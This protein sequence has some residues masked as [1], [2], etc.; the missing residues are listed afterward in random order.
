M[1]AKVSWLLSTSMLGLAF[2]GLVA[3][4]NDTLTGTELCIDDVPSTGGIGGMEA[5]AGKVI[6][7][8]LRL[9]GGV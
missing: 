7:S 5:A 8:Q 6:Q 3:D 2:S 1:N 9:S 4:V